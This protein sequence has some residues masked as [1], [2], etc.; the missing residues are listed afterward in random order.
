[1]DDNKSL[2]FT[3]TQI[4]CY[5]PGL[6]NA[7]DERWTIPLHNRIGPLAFYGGSRFSFV[8]GDRFLNDA[9][10]AEPGEVNIYDMNGEQTGLFHLGRR[11]TYLS[12]GHNH[13]IVGADRRFYALNHRGVRIWDYQTIHDTR[14]FIFLDNIDTVLIAGGTRASIMKRVRVRPEEIMQGEMQ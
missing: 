6:G 2:V 8:T 13:V 1:M 4:I 9:A 14:G 3:D 7:L 12:M 10:A 11:A 5:Q